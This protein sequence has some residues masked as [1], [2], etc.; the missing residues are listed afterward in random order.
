VI[1]TTDEQKQISTI[2]AHELDY[3]RRVQRVEFT[4]GLSIDQLLQ[5]ANS[6]QSS[7]KSEIQLNEHR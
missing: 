6:P 5:K 4:K 7:H 1:M 3:K 2:E